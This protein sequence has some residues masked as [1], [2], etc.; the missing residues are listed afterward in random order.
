MT[1]KLQK[2]QSSNSGFTLIE[3]S[4][5]LIIIGLIVGGVLFG[6]DLIKA[7]EIR[8]A[9][10]QKEKY[11]AA[12]NAFRGKYSGLPGDLG[13]Y[14][15][16]SGQLTTTGLDGTN[17]FGDGDNL[18]EGIGGTGTDNIGFVGEIKLFWKHLSEAQMISDNTSLITTAAAATIATNAQNYLPLSKLGKGSFWY[19]ANAGGLNYYGMAGISTLATAT[20]MNVA[21][22][23]VIS[24][25]EAYQLDVKLDDG[26]PISGIVTSIASITTLDTSPAGGATSGDC[27]DTDTNL[28]AIAATAEVNAPTCVLRIRASF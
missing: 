21:S 13:S 16:F 11:D 17:G 5:V 3:L 8:G 24:P 1:N 14:A 6:Q 2:K 28:Y 12:V 25:N 26:I 23:D 4:I 19:I 10:S 20:S 15:T 9:V 7:S 18:V 27:Y 22:T